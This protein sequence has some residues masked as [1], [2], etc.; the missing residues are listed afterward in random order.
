M[1][2]PEDGDNESTLRER[3]NAPTF[4]QYY[5]MCMRIKNCLRKSSYFTGEQLLFKNSVSYLLSSDPVISK[6]SQHLFHKELG[7]L[8]NIAQNSIITLEINI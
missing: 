5:F 2:G 6:G 7:G 8:S 1:E 4:I 3:K